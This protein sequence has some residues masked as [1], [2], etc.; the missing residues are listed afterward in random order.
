MD[1]WL[2]GRL[3]NSTNNR[4]PY[5]A[6][7]K[8]LLN[9]NEVDAK[10]K[11]TSQLFVKNT[12]ENIDVTHPN[13]TNRG[14]F[15]RHKIMSES[16]SFDMEGPIM[17]DLFQL[18]RYIMNQIDVQVKLYRSPPSFLLMATQSD[19]NYTI[20]IDDIVLQIMR[21]KVN[22]SVIYGHNTA[23]SSTMAKYFYPRT[24]VKMMSIPRGQVAFTYDNIFQGVRPNKVVVGFVASNAVAGDYSRNP[25]NFTNY[26]LS[27]I[28]LYCDGRNVGESGPI[29]LQFDKTHGQNMMPAFANLFRFNGCWTVDEG[30]I[31]SQSTVYL[32]RMDFDRGYALYAF[33]LEPLSGRS[34]EQTYQKQGNLRLEA[35]FATALPVTVTYIVYAEFGNGF[36]SAI[37]GL[38]YISI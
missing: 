30:G 21:V 27:Q 1:V 20:H 9:T 32:D 35:Q 3:I 8:T 2:Q 16:K 7:L 34:H 5:K 19:E 36:H 37:E 33:S 4:Y 6:I 31:D 10:S 17:H 38:S 26:D 14:M 23:L 13:S 29:K 12:A 15:E 11:L 25:F 18:R 24:E 22:P 28:A